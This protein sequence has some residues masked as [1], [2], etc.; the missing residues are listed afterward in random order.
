MRSQINKALQVSQVRFV[1]P[2][3]INKFREATGHPSETNAKLQELWNNNV[4]STQSS[5]PFKVIT[6][7]NDVY[8]ECDFASTIYSKFPKENKGEPDTTKF[9][10]MAK[11][12]AA[13]INSGYSVMID[14]AY[15]TYNDWR[16]KQLTVYEEEPMKKYASAKGAWLQLSYA[17]QVVTLDENGNYVIAIDQRVYE[18]DYGIVQVNVTAKNV[19]DSISYY[20]KFEL[21]YADGVTFL[22]NNFSPNYKYTVVDNTLKLNSDTSIAPGESYTETLYFEF[23]PVSNNNNAGRLL[24]SSEGRTIINRI[25]ANIDQTQNEGYSSVRQVIDSAFVIYY[26][27]EEKVPLDVGVFNKG[28]FTHPV[29]DITITTT[30]TDYANAKYSLYRMTRDIDA[31]MK[32]LLDKA[33]TSVYEDTPISP[34]QTADV[35]QYAVVYRAEMYNENDKYVTSLTVEYVANTNK[36][37]DEVGD[38]NKQ[39][40][41]WIPIV[42]AIAGAIVIGVI[43]FLIIRCA[44]SKKEEDVNKN[45]PEEKPIRNVNGQKRIQFNNNGNVYNDCVSIDNTKRPALKGEDIRVHKFKT[46]FDFDY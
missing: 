25:V 12:S 8:L 18:G 28:N 14:N 2:E 40:D 13:Q 38:G 31:G 32:T 11:L 34:E 36:D 5:I 1:T 46:T 7:G 29:L 37:I 43:V 42:A 9:Y 19:G 44:R 35:N 4:V 16:N 24:S 26:P 10:F 22:E 17:Y 33:T 41:L 23:A 3:I 27:Q 15:V 20:T 6:Q 39:N 30:S 21:D 45:Y